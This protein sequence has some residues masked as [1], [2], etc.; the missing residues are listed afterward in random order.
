MS[1][2][3]FSSGI[4]WT[5]MPICWSSSFEPL[6][7]DFEVRVVVVLVGGVQFDELLVDQRRVLQGQRRVRPEVRVR[8]AIRFGKLKSNLYSSGVIV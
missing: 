4:V 7:Q 8:F 2:L 1:S 3:R 5:A 6:L